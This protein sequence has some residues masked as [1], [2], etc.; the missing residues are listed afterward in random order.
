M[1]YAKA[2][3]STL[4]RGCDVTLSQRT[5]LV[6]KNGGG[7]ST[8]V[9]SLEL[10]LGGYVTD[11]E[12]RDIV[13]RNSAIGRLFGPD[14][15]MEVT[16]EFAEGQTFT[17]CMER[18]SK[19]GSY[20]DP[21]AVRP[22]SVKWPFAHL[23]GVLAGDT[24]AVVAWLESR[25]SGG[26]GLKEDFLRRVPPN[27]REEMEA[28]LNKRKSM[29]FLKLAKEAKSKAR[30]MRSAATRQEKT[31]HSMTDGIPTPLLDSD[32]ARIQADL[33]KLKAKPK[34]ITQ[35]EYDAQKSA[36]VQEI[37]D[38]ERLC[39]KMA[40]IQVDEASFRKLDRAD[41]AL[42]LIS[43]HMEVF[44]GEDCW[45]CGEGK[46][47]S[48]E[49]RKEA[50]TSA[51]AALRQQTAGGS[52]KQLLQARTTSQLK[53]IQ[54]KAEALKALV[55]TEDTSGQYDELI[56]R[57]AADDAA[58]RSW[59]NAEA[60]LQVIAHNRKQADSYAAIAKT[61]ERVGKKILKEKKQGFVDKVNAFLP[62]GEKFGM[63]LESGRVGF[64][65]EG[66]LHTALSGAE[67]T[68]LLLALGASEEGKSTPCIMVPDDRDWDRDT[69]SA[70][71][72]AL[73]D[74]PFQIIMMS[75]SM[76]DAH[77]AWSIV[78]V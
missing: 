16:V 25:V 9:Q 75:T 56:K 59:Q 27:E 62:R 72:E 2:V 76:P 13:K 24:S 39:V 46:V 38:Y 28:F 41:R 60:E 17:W 32:R 44:A 65:R 15:P 67:W 78:Q 34:G 5:V 3:K 54:T 66:V 40:S 11:M 77:D 14:T 23:K 1:N 20:K 7:K 48:I 63:D 22:M 64:L 36:L 29:D 19:P 47:A 6:G 8:V 71:M 37:A 74:C 10:A 68:Q 26:E 33:D 51:I 70:V 53:A 58:R 4:K 73:K 12:G 18:G 42:H 31:V 57:L 30:S 43:T 55:I 50:L 49:S 21:E 35:E 45:V 52:E 61:L 69:L